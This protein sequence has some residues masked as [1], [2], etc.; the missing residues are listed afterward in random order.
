MSY[1]YPINFYL[2]W[3]LYIT[4]CE[5][6]DDVCRKAGREREEKHSEGG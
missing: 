3:N 6:I 5:G 4:Y 2:F 1:A